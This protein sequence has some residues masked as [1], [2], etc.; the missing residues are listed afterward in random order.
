MKIQDIKDKTNTMNYFLL[1][2]GGRIEKLERGHCE[3]VLTLGKQHQNYNE[4]V[5]GGVM[6]TL[7]DAAAGAA[8]L[9]A[10]AAAGFSAPA[11]RE[12]RRMA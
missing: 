2:T 8:A 7:I 10:G 11:K 5:H 4:M 6:L 1:H 3:I 12:T 9:A